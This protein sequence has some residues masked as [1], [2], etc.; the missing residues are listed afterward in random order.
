MATGVPVAV[1]VFGTGNAP[2]CRASIVCAGVAGW[3]SKNRIMVY[4]ALPS[5]VVL[6]FDSR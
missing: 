4:T 6:G 3:I 2:I 5:F 1:P